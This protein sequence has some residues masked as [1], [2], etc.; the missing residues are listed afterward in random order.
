[1]HA[2]GENR[3]DITGAA[4]PCYHSNVRVVVPSNT[5]E[6][7]AQGMDDPVNWQQH[8]VALDQQRGRSRPARPVGQHDRTTCRYRNV[9]SGN[10]DRHGP[11]TL[12]IRSP[13]PNIGINPVPAGF[14]NP[15]VPT[16]DDLL[17]A[18][19]CDVIS[20]SAKGGPYRSKGTK[21]T[22]HPNYIGGN[23][24]RLCDEPRVGIGEDDLGGVGGTG[25]VGKFRSSQSAAHTTQKLLTSH[26][27]STSR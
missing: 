13:V 6:R 15:P 2:K 14:G 8:D 22:G 3:L 17:Q 25:N 21:S 11:D 27:V 5:V 4:G 9:G 24:L 20:L 19:P 12:V 26:G 10:A 7:L 16:G 1:M 18:I 23:T